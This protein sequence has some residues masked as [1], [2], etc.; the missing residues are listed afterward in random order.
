MSLNNVN[1]NEEELFFGP[2]NCCWELFYSS[3]LEQ[4]TA[5]C[6]VMNNDSIKLS[7]RMATNK[8]YIT[9]KTK[10]VDGDYR[11]YV[12]DL[13]FTVDPKYKKASPWI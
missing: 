7:G 3:A 13:N 8:R 12:E 2:K 6:I 4:N 10:K 1:K 9:G 11:F 5:P